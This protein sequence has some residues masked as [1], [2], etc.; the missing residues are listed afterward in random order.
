MVPS[1]LD[2]ALEKN[3]S[4][5]LR[6]DTLKKRF[7]SAHFKGAAITVNVVRLGTLKFLFLANLIAS[8]LYFEGI[9]V[10]FIGD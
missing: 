9:T 4:K 10:R 3:Q 1:P 8:K 7:Y 5:K 6:Q 2:N